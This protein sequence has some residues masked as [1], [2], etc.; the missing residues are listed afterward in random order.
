MIECAT[1][2]FQQDGYHGTSWRRLV[3]ESGTP[4]GSIQHHF[5]GGKEEL[6][7]AAIDLGADAV[8]ALLDHCFAASAAPDLAVRRWF[9]LTTERMSATDFRSGCPVALVALETTPSSPALSEAS[10]RAFT[11][12]EATL[13]TH[14]GKAHLPG[15][16]ARELARI[17][18]TLM[19]GALLLAR[20]YGS[21]DPLTRA[22]TQAADLVRAAVTQ[23]HE[24]EDA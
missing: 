2:L 1:R 21:G 17:V 11:R 14:F 23:A 6:G 20:V 22:S 3:D 15:R 13:A 9:Q 19:E 5:P 10:R 7:V 8:V 16:R 24:A 4:W 18:L 12:W